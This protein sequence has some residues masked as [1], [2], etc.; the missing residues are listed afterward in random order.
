MPDSSIDWVLVWHSMVLAFAIVLRGAWS[1]A[2]AGP[3]EPA[4]QSVPNT[5]AIAICRPDMRQSS[6]P[7]DALTNQQI[8]LDS[9]R[10]WS[11]AC[12]QL[13]AAWPAP[14]GGAACSDLAAA[15]KCTPLLDVG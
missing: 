11:S 7:L 2:A 12:C 15:L 14:V 6:L 9:R 1:L 5:H 13:C 8:G 4:S 10:P 3:G